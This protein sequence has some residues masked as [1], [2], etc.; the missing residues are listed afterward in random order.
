MDYAPS[1]C[2][3]G[4]FSNYPSSAVG[5]T[6][7]FEGGPWYAS[8]IPGR[9]SRAY[10][11]NTKFYEL[12]SGRVGK[13]PPTPKVRATE[14]QRLAQ[15]SIPQ[16]FMDFYEPGVYTKKYGYGDRVQP[17][18]S[19]QQEKFTNGQAPW[20]V[21]DDPWYATNYAD[22]VDYGTY[23]SKRYQPIYRAAA[24]A[25]TQELAALYNNGKPVGSGNIE[26]FQNTAE[27][28]TNTLKIPDWCKGA[29]R[30][31]YMKARAR[32]SA[33]RGGGGRKVERLTAGPPLPESEL[34]KG[35]PLFMPGSAELYVYAGSQTQ[36]PIPYRGNVPIGT[37]Y[38]EW[39]DFL[40]YGCT[41]V[42][43]D[44]QYNHVS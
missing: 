23:E 5:T 37:R 9:D 29:C 20:Y 34:K 27:Y 32:A 30:D 8:N 16:S 22:N 43:C 12:Q 24:E 21:S 44:E 13:G 19:T 17:V 40:Q 6:E 33:A 31:R 10:E 26:T 4:N 15:L 36:D 42:D 1:F 3:P 39:T 35:N 11:N 2:D 18:N 38:P 25:R 14:Q 7:R 41:T 28:G